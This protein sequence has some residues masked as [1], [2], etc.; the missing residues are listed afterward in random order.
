MPELDVRAD[1]QQLRPRGGLERA[2]P[3]VEPAPGTPDQRRISQ[4][5]GGREQHQSLRCLLKLADAA[6][7]VVLDVCRQVSGGGQ[8][9]AACQFRGRHVPRQLQQGE[10]IA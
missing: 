3:E 7:I 1:L 9:E 6:Q 8:L 2:S 4:R 10:R 5:V